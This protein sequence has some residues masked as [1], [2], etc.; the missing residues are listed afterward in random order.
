MM[1]SLTRLVDRYGLRVLSRTSSEQR[2]YFKFDSFDF[3]HTDVE[4]FGEDYKTVG[5]ILRPYLEK[6]Y[7]DKALF[8]AEFGAWSSDFHK[9][10]ED[11]G[12]KLIKEPLLVVWLPGLSK[13]K[14]IVICS[15]SVHDQMLESAISLLNNDEKFARAVM[16]SM[17]SQAIKT[18]KRDKNFVAFC[19]YFGLFER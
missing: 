16:Y 17:K 3:F 19:E 18:L 13:E 15:K 9:T 11:L 12:M 10:F 4:V 7:G 2:K 8:T 6:Q 14:R 5:N 1:T